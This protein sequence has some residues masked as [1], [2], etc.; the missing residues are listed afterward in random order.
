MSGIT[1]WIDWERDLSGEQDVLSKMTNAI[2]HRGP[3]DEGY[4]FSERAAIGHRRLFVIDPAGGKQ[5]MVYRSGDHSIVLSYN[6]FIYN[7][8]DLKAELENLGH[9]FKSESDAEVLLHSYLEWGEEFVQRINGV[10]AFAIWDERRQALILGRDRIGVKPLFYKVH[11]SG[12]L[13][14]SELKAI[15]AHPEVKP[16][17]DVEGFSEV[18]GMGPVRTP[19][20][21]VFRGIQE[22]KQGHYIV[23]T[24]DKADHRQYWKLESKPHEDDVDTTVEKIREILKDNVKRQLIADAPVVSML[25]GGLDS[26]GL[27]SM[28]ARYLAEEGKQLGTYSLDFAGSDQHFKADLLHVSRDEP[29]VKIVAEYANTDHHTV[30]I[31]HDQ[32]T[33]H[34]FL[35]VKAHDLPALGEMEASLHLLFR[36]MK[37]NAV[38]TLSGESADEVFSGYP[39]FHQDEF[40]FSGTFPWSAQIRYFKEVLNEEAIN[41]LQP[42]EHRNRRYQE[43]VSEVPKLDGETGIE[44]KQREMS[45]LFITRFL[46][47]M[48]ERKDRISMYNGFEARVPFSDYRLVQYLFNIPYSMKTVDKVEKSLL[49]RA[50]KGYLPEEVRTRKKSAYPSTTDPVYYQNIRKM[51]NELIED[52]KA[53]VVPLLDKQKIHHISDNL[54]EKSPFEVGKM[55]EYILQINKWMQDYNISLKL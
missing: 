21:G 32:L 20:F 15:L 7:F 50:F 55:M 13:F 9:R 2:Q 19:G 31:N 48:L 16:E 47:F 11:N 8:K 17:V 27:T 44:E 37:K 33:E 52:P 41:T 22:V 40:L 23:F 54:F 25:S 42:E 43:A 30:V 4:W 6:G 18:F 45:Y 12:V 51:L 36:E 1:G 26:S 53:P 5:P 24:K 35:P 14:G 34:V 3:D 28:A 49:R 38:A 39:W 29:F 46:P 10:F